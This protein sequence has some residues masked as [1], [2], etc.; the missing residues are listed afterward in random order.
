MSKT[1]RLTN[2]LIESTRPTKKDQWLSDNDG[3]RSWGRLLLRVSPNGDR[4][5][6]FRY[7]LDGKRTTLALGRYAKR[8]TAGMLTLTEA[9]KISVR[10]SALHRDPSTRDI[11]QH[12]EA[13]E[14]TVRRLDGDAHVPPSPAQSLDKSDSLLA[15]CNTYVE[16]LE[17]RKAQSAP[18]VRNY[19]KNHVAPTE[20]AN[21]SAREITPK[22]I[23][24]L[25]RKIV[26]AGKGTTAQ[27]V[28][29]TL[30]AAYSLAADATLDATAPSDMELFKIEVNPV[31][32]TKKLAYL[33]IPG[34]R[35]LDRKELGH[36]WR[37]VNRPES[38]LLLPVR[39]IRLTTLLGGQRAL[40]L[41][42]CT[43]ISVDLENGHLT[44]YDGKGRRESPRI[45][46]LPI[47]DAARVEIDWLLQ[48]SE[49]VGSTYLFSGRNPNQP[50]SD[51]PISRI[52]NLLSKKLVA[53]KKFKAP[54]KY[55]D[56]RR[57]IETN[58]ASVD[59]I[60]DVRA[61]IQSHGLGGIQNKHYNKHDYFP[62]KLA[63]L[64]AWAMHL[65]ACA[66]GA[67]V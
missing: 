63:A 43:T 27:K 3:N 4:R 55:A 12:I 7:S 42:R 65:E 37:E 67:A 10:Y 1:N 58:M 33:S 2:E 52:V 28:R 16:H 50:L 13:G 6:Y 24:S 11:K 64:K 41:L 18:N 66:K 31:S 17:R 21:I 60:D 61:R 38:D 34:E 56:L 46:C 40:Q 54:F 59:I 49:S 45:H 47:T 32:P 39:F 36:F 62:Q 14:I 20:W 51:G 23:T 5:F 8:P 19:I 26:D 30:Q 29:Q 35:S 44:L 15:L 57:S 9:R 48:H 53:E 25:L 22:N